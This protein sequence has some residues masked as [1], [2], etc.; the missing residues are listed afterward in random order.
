MNKPVRVRPSIWL[1]QCEVDQ[2][3]ELYRSLPAN[4]CAVIKCISLQSASRLLARRLK[5]QL[6]LLEGKP[7]KTAQHALAQLKNIQ[8]DLAVFLISQWDN[9]DLTQGWL[10]DDL[11]G[12]VRPHAPFS[13]EPLNTYGLSEREV[14]VLKLMI[15]GFIKKE[16]AGELAISYYT[17]DHHE[18]HILK[19]MQ[20]H[21]RTAAVAK[22]LIENI[23]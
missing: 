19:K 3:S 18:R 5:P 6:I 4:L 17:V 9:A 16:I 13:T 7:S 11:M 10:A 23:C 20:V 14:A 8:P 15:R 2:D 12:L 22:A 21:S 1:V